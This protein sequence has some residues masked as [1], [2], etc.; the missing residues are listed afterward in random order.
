MLLVYSYACVGAGLGHVGQQWGP[1]WLRSASWSGGGSSDK[2]GT[3]VTASTSTDA[4]QAG[5]KTGPKTYRPF[6]ATEHWQ[7]VADDHV[8][9]PGV[10]TPKP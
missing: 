6:E 3:G 8:L 5:K 10:R 2:D 1:A 9:P 7:A 4:D